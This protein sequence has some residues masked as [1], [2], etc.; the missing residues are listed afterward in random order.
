LSLAATPGDPS[1]GSGPP[2]PPVLSPVLIFRVEDVFTQA[3]LDY[4]SLLPAE[5]HDP[6]SLR[7]PFQALEGLKARLAAQ[8]YQATMARFELG[9]KR[10]EDEEF[11]TQVAPPATAR[12]LRSTRT[13][14]FK[15]AAYSSVDESV[16]R[17]F[18]TR[19]G[20]ITDFDYLWARSALNGNVITR[21]SQGF[22]GRVDPS[23]SIFFSSRPE[24][25]KAVK[26]LGPK[27]VLLPN[28][29][30]S[31]RMQMLAKPDA[32]IINLDEASTMLELPSWR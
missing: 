26:A 1:G 28:K 20:L 25:V 9:A 21:L 31:G 14:A 15:L 19:S 17:A 23:R 5:L 30:E 2:A 24:D 18:L 10:I 3:R 29:R 8:E 22:P 27:V 11:R 13:G 12:A 7:N 32:Y 16:I 6:A 4:S